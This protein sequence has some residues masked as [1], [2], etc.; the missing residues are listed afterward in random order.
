MNTLPFLL[1]DGV[2]VLRLGEIGSLEAKIRLE[3]DEP[4][5]KFL[6][7]S[8]AEE[9]DFED[10]WLLDIRLYSRSFRADR[11]S[12]LLQ[13]LGLVNQHLRLHIADRR[14]FFDAKERLQKLKQLVA[15]DDSA[16]DLDR[17]MLAVVARAE[18]PELFNLVR[19]LFHA[20]TEAGD[21]IDLDTPPPAWEQVEKFDL[22]EPFW[23]MVK[24]TFGYAE[25]SPGLR[26]FL[27]RLLLTD[28]AYH[29]K[30]DVPTSLQHLLLPRS[31]WPNAVVC[32]AQW[33]D[34]ASKGGSYDRLSALAAAVLKI[35][36]HL[37][38]LEIDN[39]I[40][41][42]TFLAVEKRV[43]SSLR[44]RVQATAGTVNA[45]DVQ[46]VAT[47]R[48]AGHW[49]SLS[50]AGAKETPRQA[51]HAV[52]DALVAA[53]GFYALR[54]QYRHGFDYP[55]AATMYRAYEEEL[56]RFDQLYR[57]FCEAADEAEVQG[58]SILKS[59]RP[60]SRR[61][62]PTGSCRPWP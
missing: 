35:E 10:D 60:R 54:N 3:R 32:L 28:Y 11:P 2:T 31:G 43:A 52:Y 27:L 55:D 41:V 40:D 56:C 39:L 25:D 34:S 23:Q 36:D 62:T 59:L 7:Y 26:N 38:K 24:A 5:A 8:P 44:D 57:H 22:A 30:G 15:A 51:L 47:R 16:A 29:L 46:A 33:R 45:E 49:A 53:T 19:T 20:Y 50:V 61:A 48:Q 9:P 37:P 1:L 58:W 21:E 12:I 13:E 4:R 14:K 18:Q 42:M 17:K 6:L